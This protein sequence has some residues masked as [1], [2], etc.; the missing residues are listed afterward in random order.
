MYS[1]CLPLLAHALALVVVDI[2]E[3]LCRV[4]VFVVFLLF[5]CCSMVVTAVAH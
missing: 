1:S 4:I 3:L 2:R 5:C